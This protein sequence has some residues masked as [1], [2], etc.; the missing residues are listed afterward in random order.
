MSYKTVL[1]H[2]DKSRSTAER[3]K[4]A[5]TVAM[6]EQAHLVGAALTGTSR[7][8]YEAG[9]INSNDPNLTTHLQEQLEVL[10][11]R[12]R[13]AL[14]EFETLV[15]TM[16][17]RS[18][19]GQLI[20]DEPGS[21]INQKARCNDLVVIGQ[22]DPEEL[23]SPIPP[24]FPETVVL[25]SG[26]P[27]LIVP[28]IGQFDRIGSNVLIAWDASVSATHAVTNAIPLLRRADQVEIVVFL[29]EGEEMPDQAGDDIAAYLAHHGVKANVTRQA[30]KT[31]KKYRTKL[32]IG[33]ALLSMATDLNSD[34]IVMGAYGHSR[35]RELLLGGVTRTVM[36]SMTV[37]V[38]MSH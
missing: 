1:V 38:L 10:R 9:L 31:D 7:Y 25:H 35:L 24:D 30:T 11:D 8:L 4:V 21:G 14:N 3:I 2:V 20:D 18:F 26:R 6:N 32:D 17:V 23:S 37:P 13:D 22:T 15:R 28:Y 12:A 16:Q 34:L 5:A 33:N 29:S 27:V 19:E 36:Q